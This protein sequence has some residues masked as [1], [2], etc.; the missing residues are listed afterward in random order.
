[1]N[2]TITLLFRKLFVGALLSI[3]CVLSI[4][5]CGPHKVTQADIN[6]I[7]NNKSLSGDQKT[8]AIDALNPDPDT[9]YYGS[10]G[11]IIV[12]GGCAA[13]GAVMVKKKMDASAHAEID[14]SSG[15]GSARKASDSSKHQPAMPTKSSKTAQHGPPAKYL[16]QFKIEEPPVKKLPASKAEVESIAIEERSMSFFTSRP[17]PLEA[18]QQVT[19]R[20]GYKQFTVMA[21]PEEAEKCQ[22]GNFPRVRAFTIKEKTI[23]WFEWAKYDPYKHYWA[24]DAQGWSGTH[25]VVPCWMKVD[26]LD[27]KLEGYKAR[28]QGHLS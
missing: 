24:M 1:M 13:L 12:I 27:V 17:L 4:A 7:N 9:S 26:I 5:G 14:R 15:V 18:V 19:F 10:S 3:V 16:E 11:I 8:A 23:P 28:E 22:A 20:V 21:T 6:R 2:A 25:D